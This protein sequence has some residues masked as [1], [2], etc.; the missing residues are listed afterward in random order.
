MQIWNSHW[1]AC[2]HPTNDWLGQLDAE[3]T[4]FSSHPRQ[5]WHLGMDTSLCGWLSCALLGVLQHLWP[6][7]TRCQLC[8]HLHYDTPKWLQTLLNVP[9]G[10]KPLPLRAPPLPS[11]QFLVLS[12]GWSCHVA[13]INQF[14]VGPGLAPKIKFSLF[15]EGTL[16][17]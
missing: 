5:Y 15:W 10:G 1:V 3:F 6:S 16:F 8:S 11:N 13:F 12:K 2:T 17:E 14:T 9:W 4:I 7:P